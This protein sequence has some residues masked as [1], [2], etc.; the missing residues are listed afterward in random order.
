MTALTG[1]SRFLTLAAGY[2]GGAALAGYGTYLFW[3]PDLSQEQVLLTGLPLVGG[4][5]LMMATAEHQRRT[6]ARSV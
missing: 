5:G 2:V 6:A 3:L 4:I 1:V